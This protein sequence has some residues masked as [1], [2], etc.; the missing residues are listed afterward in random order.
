LAKHD[1]TVTMA[2]KRIRERAAMTMQ[3]IAAALQRAEAAVRRRP[4]IALHD[5]A[6]ATARWKHGMEVVSS[7]ANGTQVSTDMPTEIGGGGESVTPGWLLRASIASCAATSIAMT[8][9]VEGIELT[10]LE[11]VAQSRSDLRGLL[12]MSDAE[13]ALVDAGPRDVRLLVRIAARGLSEARVRVL[14]E[15]GLRCS[16]VPSALTN[17]VP[18]DIRVEIEGA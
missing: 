3:D 6:P 11:V 9:A 18:V 13:G 12:G 1:E 15:H 16:P 4:D 5:D 2:W 10:A 14:V 7:H 8:A 17:K